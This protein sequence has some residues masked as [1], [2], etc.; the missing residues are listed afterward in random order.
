MIFP[1]AYSV[2]NIMKNYFFIFSILLAATSANSQITFYKIFTNLK[3]YDGTFV[4]CNMDDPIQKR[5]LF[6][7]GAVYISKSAILPKRCRFGDEASVT[8]FTKRL[9]TPGNQ[10]AFGKFY[11][12]P[13][14]KKSLEAVF[15]QLKGYENVARNCNGRNGIGCDATSQENSVKLNDDWALRTYRDTLCNW[16][17]GNCAEISNSSIIDEIKNDDEDVKPA[18][19]STAIPGGSQHHLGLAIDVN[20]DG[21][22]ICGKDCQSVLQRNGWYR[23]VPF[24]S[25]HFTFL[26][27]LEF[28]LP[29]KGLKKVKCD[30]FEYWVPYVT[31]PL[32]AGYSYLQKEIG[33]NERR[34]RDVQ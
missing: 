23:T 12:Q 2:K 30:G 16:G 26:G 5:I 1:L 14:A 13:Q 29:D 21:E 22:R 28:E 20:D 15:R 10:L 32:Y 34:C 11:L 19:F 6:E 9:K 8:A 7:Y 25:Y 27:F 3:A 18:M 33:Q 17:H 24:D 4:K 31:A